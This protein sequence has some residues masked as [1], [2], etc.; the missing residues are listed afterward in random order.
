MLKVTEIA[1]SCYAVID[2]AMICNPE[3]NTLC[4]HKRNAK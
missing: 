1:F 2:I 4:I 3:G